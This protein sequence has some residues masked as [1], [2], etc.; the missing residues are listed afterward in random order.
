MPGC[1]RLVARPTSVLI[2]AAALYCPK[3]YALSIT[4]AGVV[5]AV[6]GRAGD[7][8]GKDALWL[9]EG[10]LDLE[11]WGTISGG[12]VWQN[13]TTED[14]S[15]DLIGR[16]VLFERTR[17]VPA[18]YDYALAKYNGKNA[19]WVLFYVGGKETTLPRYSYSLWTNNPG[20]Y[21][22]SNFTA[23]HS[24]PDGGSAAGLLAAALA[25]LG[26]LRRKLRMD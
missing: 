2:I 12:R 19:G 5:G 21:E 23:F 14:Y 22:I 16:G 4:D 9:A 13:N 7:N 15:G 20:K 10:I 24:V 18:G 26:L 3:A 17:V 25:G 11:G 8:A 1:L 6:D